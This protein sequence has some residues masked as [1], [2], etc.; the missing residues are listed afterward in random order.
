MLEAETGASD[1]FTTLY[2]DAMS[3]VAGPTN[4][5]DAV[6]THRSFQSVTFFRT[7]VIDF[8]CWFHPA[9]FGAYQ[10]P[11]PIL[12][13]SRAYSIVRTLVT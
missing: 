12:T 10:R 1:G 8:H 9:R 7:A 5:D 13:H 3:I 4:V 6:G 11:E 2:E